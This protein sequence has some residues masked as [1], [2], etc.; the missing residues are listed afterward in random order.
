MERYRKAVPKSDDERVTSRQPF[1]IRV[2]HMLLRLR[3]WVILG[4]Y[5]PVLVFSGSDFSLLVGS[6]CSFL[7]CFLIFIASVR[8]DWAQPASILVSFGASAR[9]LFGDARPLSHVTTSSSNWTSSNGTVGFGRLIV[10][11]FFLLVFGKYR[12]NFSFS[13][14]SFLYKRLC[15]LWGILRRIRRV[16]ICVGDARPLSHAVERHFVSVGHC[17]SAQSIQWRLMR[18]AAPTAGEWQVPFVFF[19]LRFQSKVIDPLILNLWFAEL[20]SY[21]VLLSFSTFDILL[22]QCFG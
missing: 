13:L 20:C 22:I 5:S 21:W 15:Y 8:L 2:T 7:F 19:F 1:F 3:Y 16:L 17:P 18:L 10:C 6:P 12:S 9:I 11:L 4:F 14:N